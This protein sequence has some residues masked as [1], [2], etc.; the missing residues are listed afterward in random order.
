MRNIYMVVRAHRPRCRTL[1]VD[2]GHA[3]DEADHVD[4]RP[5]LAFQ[6]KMP[7]IVELAERHHRAALDEVIDQ[8]AELDMC[9]TTRSVRFSRT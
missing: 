8:F 3:V 6:S 5:H 9:R 4:L 1:R 2:R 7:R